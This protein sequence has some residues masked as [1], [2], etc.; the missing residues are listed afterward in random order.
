VIFAAFLGFNPIQH[1]IGAQ[2]L[3]SLPASAVAQLSSRDYFPSLI[4]S[5]FHSGL[6]EAFGFA[7]LACVIAAIASWS[8]GKRYVHDE[9]PE[10]ERA[11]DAV[12]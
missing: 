1:L 10:L 9:Q 2:T 7:A 6:D 12:C 5:A 8:R 4:S 11:E 3:A